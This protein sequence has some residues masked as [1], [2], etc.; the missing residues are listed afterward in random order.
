M[1]D[2]P[3]T[4]PTPAGETA[5]G[6][7]VAVDLGAVAGDGGVVWSVSPGGFHTNL[8]V[9]AAGGSIA[10]HRNDALDVLHVVL[11]GSATLSIDGRAVELGAEQAVLVPRG[12]T[13]AVTA[14]PAGVRYLTVHRPRPPL[15]IGAPGDARV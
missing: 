1:R 14:G 4:E 3:V 9:L 2:Q 11:T 6:E 13:R 8:V 15:G 5:A 7:A 12:T 10:A